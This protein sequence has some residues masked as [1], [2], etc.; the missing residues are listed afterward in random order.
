MMIS[1]KTYIPGAGLLDQCA[2]WFI[3][4]LLAFCLTGCS[5]EGDKPPPAPVSRPGVEAGPTRPDDD[6]LTVLGVKAPRPEDDIPAS[7][8]RIEVHEPKFDEH[9]R[10]S[11]AAPRPKRASPLDF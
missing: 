3:P 7:G 5:G 9:K 6:V 8:L 2:L 10:E 4:V 11:E 1:V